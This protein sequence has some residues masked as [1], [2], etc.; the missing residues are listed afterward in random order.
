MADDKT[1]TLPSL[2]DEGELEIPGGL[3]GVNPEST[4]L[5]GAKAA[6]ATPEVKPEPLHPTASPAEPPAVTDE[7][8]TAAREYLVGEGVP[9]V[10]LNDSAKDAIVDWAATS[11]DKKETEVSE[12]AAMLDKFSKQMETPAAAQVASPLAPPSPGIT[13]LDLTMEEMTEAFGEKGSKAW[14][15]QLERQNQWQNQMQA[16][17]K[18]VLLMGNQL[19]QTAIRNFVKE[20]KDTYPS[21]D[22]KEGLQK[23]LDKAGVLAR[24][25]EYPTYDDVFVDAAGLVFANDEGGKQ[26]ARRRRIAG[27]K[28]RGQATKPVDAPAVVKF[29]SEQLEDK[30]AELVTQG[31]EGREEAERL[32]EQFKAGN[33]GLIL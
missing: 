21:L 2:D 14:R 26:A 16:Y 12:M 13:D 8:Y 25:S 5:L 24:T 17:E 33:T 23:M 28:T 9:A 6:E 3:F 1:P 11:A 31:K 20:N 22:T 15:S 27:L 30:I 10:L 18:A 4:E 7:D 29:T 32:S 19:E